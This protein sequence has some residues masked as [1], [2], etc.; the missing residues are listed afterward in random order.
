M[1]TPVVSLPSVRRFWHEIR[2][3]GDY[4]EYC[5]DLL[6]RAIRAGYQVR[7]TPYRCVPRTAGESKTGVNLWDYLVK[8]RKY[9]ETIW[10]LRR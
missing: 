3:H 6:A 8:G 4:G 1:I 2:L 10:R 5:I 7:E 9:V